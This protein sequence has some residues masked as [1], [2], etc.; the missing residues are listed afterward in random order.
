MHAQPFSDNMIRI[1]KTG[2]STPP[3]TSS[4]EKAKA[5]LPKDLQIA[6]DFNDRI[7]KSSLAKYYYSI[8][9]WT[10]RLILPEPLVS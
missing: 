7:D 8:A 9:E 2:N 6:L 3:A 4:P 5:I 10:G 1:E